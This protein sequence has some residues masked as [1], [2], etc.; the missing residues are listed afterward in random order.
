[1][2]ITMD[3]GGPFLI[4]NKKK[5][6]YYFFFFFYEKQA[7]F[8]SSFHFCCFW[9]KVLHDLAWRQTRYVAE[10]DLGPLIL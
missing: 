6:F 1:M 3:L 2:F 10:D 5:A 4:K 9:D 7:I 8:F